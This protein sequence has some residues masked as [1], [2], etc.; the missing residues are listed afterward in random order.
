[1]SLV[2]HCRRSNLFSCFSLL[3]FVSLDG[4][5]LRMLGALHLAFVKSSQVFMAGFVVEIDLFNFRRSSNFALFQILGTHDEQK[6]QFKVYLNQITS[7]TLYIAGCVEIASKA[8]KKKVD[9]ESSGGSGLS[10]ASEAKSDTSRWQHHR[11]PNSIPT[12]N[13][14]HLS[15]F[16]LLALGAAAVNA[17][18][19]TSPFFL[20]S[21]SEYV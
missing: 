1:M 21:T 18:R 12:P 15:R 8:K 13:T 6:S 16:G 14:M 2:T 20:A 3:L 11:Q 10:T 4:I 5:F 9:M 7:G 19:D 17:F